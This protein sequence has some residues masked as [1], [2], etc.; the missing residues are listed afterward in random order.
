MTKTRNLA[1]LGGG[2]IQAGTGA[3]QRTVESKL[4]DVVSVKDFGAVGDGVADDTAAF[5]AAF[6]ALN[7]GSGP[8]GLFIPAGNYLVAPG[9]CSITTSNRHVYGEGPTSRIILSSGPVGATGIVANGTS[10][11]VHLSDVLVSDLSVVASGWTGANG[12]NGIAFNRVDRCSVQRCTVLGDSSGQSWEQGIIFRDTNNCLIANNIVRRIKGNGISLDLI[13]GSETTS[14]NLVTGNTIS[15]VGD[16]GIGFHNNVRYSAAIGNVIDQPGQGGGTGI[17]IAGCN[18]C[19]F[20]GNTISNSAQYGIRL[21]QNLSYRTVDNVVTNNTVYHP[22]TAGAFAALQIDNTERNTITGNTLVGNTSSLSDTGIYI[23]YSSTGSQTHP[24]TGETLFKLRGSVIQANTIKRF[25]KGI[26]LDAAGGITGAT[27]LVDAN[28]IRDCTTGLSFSTASSEVRFTLSGHNQYFDCST[29]VASLTAGIARNDDI[30]RDTLAC[31]PVNTSTTQAET[32]VTTL[33]VTRVPS[34]NTALI[35][36]HRVS[37]TGAYDGRIRYKDSAGTTL[38]SDV[39][40][41]VTNAIRTTT[42]P[43]VSND[44]LTVSIEKSGTPA[45][46]TVTCNGLT[47]EYRTYY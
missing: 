19:L 38:V 24:V 28:V 1:D 41:E 27:L 32:T 9:T 14:G 34:Q 7:T 8:K 12:Q 6:A 13:I 18:C 25:A 26:S 35:A 22:S 30:I 43:L 11:T 44:L 33:L 17:D 39:F 16:S 15:F 23:S 21:L 10:D 46:G 40:G 42:I 31:I 29:N 4:Q 47:F 37:E 2:F 45:T 3:V 36:Q 5:A 20:S